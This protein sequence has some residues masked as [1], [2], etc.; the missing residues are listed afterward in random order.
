MFSLS[1][2]GLHDVRLNTDQV[3]VFVFAAVAAA[4]LYIVIRRTQVGL[5]MRAQV[6]RA[7][8]ATLRGIDPSRTSGIAW[9][10]SVTLASLAGDV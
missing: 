3:A 6:D 9:M 2:V 1:W 7:P 5:Q 4:V 10:L 8:L